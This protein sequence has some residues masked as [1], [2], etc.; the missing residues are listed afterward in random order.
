M[1]VIPEVSEDLPT[2][3]HPPLPLLLT[4]GLNYNAGGRMGKMIPSLSRQPVFAVESRG[5][6]THLLKAELRVF[7]SARKIGIPFL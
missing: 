2:H 3:W 4:I 6:G 5:E 1:I 7:T